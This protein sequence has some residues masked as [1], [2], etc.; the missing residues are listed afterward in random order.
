MTIIRTIAIEDDIFYS[1]DFQKLARERKVSKTVNDLLRAHINIK[2]SEI[3]GDEAG[4]EDALRDVAAKKALL[5]ERK[6]RLERQK[7]K[8][9]VTEDDLQK[10]AREKFSRGF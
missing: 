4:L 8:E 6:E 2:S 10:L 3:P 1:D 9:R 7:E 5:L